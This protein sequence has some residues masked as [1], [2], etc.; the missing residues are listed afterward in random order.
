[1]PQKAN[2]IAMKWLESKDISKTNRVN[3][4]HGIGDTTQRTNSLQEV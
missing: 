4:K 2:K 1:M 3:L